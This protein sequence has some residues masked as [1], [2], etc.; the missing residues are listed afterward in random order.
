M[1][2]RLPLL[3]DQYPK[4]RQIAPRSEMLTLRLTSRKKQ[5]IPEHPIPP[6]R[7]HG[8]TKT[9]ITSA[10]LSLRTTY[11]GRWK[12][13]IGTTPRISVSR[14]IPWAYLKTW[15]SRLSSSIPG[16]LRKVAPARLTWLRVSHQVNFEEE[17][18]FDRTNTPWKV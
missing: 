18:D 13:V 1:A 9:C 7:L 8:I 11:Y 17:P 15:P 3:L 2:S 14:S 4:S 16:R 10:M 6:T 5:E 12:S